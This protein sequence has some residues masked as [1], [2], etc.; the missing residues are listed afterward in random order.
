M[1]N[2]IAVGLLVGVESF[3][4]SGVVLWAM[5]Q[6]FHLGKVAA[7]GAIVIAVMFGLLSG[8]WIFKSALAHQGD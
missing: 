6:L 8:Y 5:S 3:A 7:D 4:F 2:A 1:L